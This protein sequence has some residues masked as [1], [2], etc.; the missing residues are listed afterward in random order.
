MM[1]IDNH[2]ANSHLPNNS[3]LQRS[4]SVTAEQ[5]SPHLPKEF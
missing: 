1:T 3:N 2:I 4:Q 5:L